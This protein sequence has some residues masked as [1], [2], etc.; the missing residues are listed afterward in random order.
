MVQ[1]GILFIKII[2]SDG[3]TLDNLEVFPNSPRLLSIFTISFLAFS[4]FVGKTVIDKSQ[5]NFIK[6]VPFAIIPVH[7]VILLFKRKFVITCDDIIC[8]IIFVTSLALYLTYESSNAMEN[9]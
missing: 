4:S 3:I 8:L 9:G 7:S 2:S 5:Y 1:C 6:T